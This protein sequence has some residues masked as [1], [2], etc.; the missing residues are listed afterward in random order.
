MRESVRLTL[1]FVARC[2]PGGNSNTLEIYLPAAVTARVVN[3]PGELHTG[4][5]GRWLGTGVLD[6][7]RDSAC[8]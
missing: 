3:A 1:L 2:K 7:Q 6:L 4:R 8:I 5:L